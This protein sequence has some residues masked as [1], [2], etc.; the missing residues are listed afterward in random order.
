MSATREKNRQESLSMARIIRA[1]RKRLGLEQRDVASILDI[2]QEKLSRIENGRQIMPHVVWHSLCEEWKL[3]YDC[4]RTQV[5]DLGSAV[6]LSNMSKAGKF[7]IPK[8]YSRNQT[9]S[10][11]IIRLFVDY[12]VRKIGEKSMN[13]FLMQSGFDPDYFVHS[14]NQV[15]IEFYFDLAAYLMERTN[16]RGEIRDV[17]APVMGPIPHGCLNQFYESEIVDAFSALRSFIQKQNF[18]DINFRFEI[19][20]ERKDRLSVSATPQIY[21][22][23][24]RS[25]FAEKHLESFTCSCTK[26]F[27]KSFSRYG[28]NPGGSLEIEH[29]ANDCF[30]HGS[31]R[32]I[33]VATS[34]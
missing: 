30:F 3:P 34:A 31:D 13:W 27:L 26:E 25:N 23:Q 22:L 16:L 18:Y 21:L 15:N 19:D 28:Q 14:N 8:A 29:S 4:F 12:G 9:T 32:C 24:K 17:F 1:H 10:V 11:R 33:F 6:S 2:G 5:V 7:K 20:D